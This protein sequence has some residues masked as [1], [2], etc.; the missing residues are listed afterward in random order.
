M[1]GNRGTLSSYAADGRV[2]II[3]K[4]LSVGK[5]DELKIT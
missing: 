1:I 4:E 2:T 5:C 3:S